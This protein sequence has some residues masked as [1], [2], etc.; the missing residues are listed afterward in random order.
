MRNPLCQ[1]ELKVINGSANGVYQWCVEH[2]PLKPEKGI[3]YQV[4]EVY[5]ITRSQRVIEKV[6]REFGSNFSFFP[7]RNRYFICV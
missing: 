5:I 1:F 4:D 7:F 2:L 3:I 6:N